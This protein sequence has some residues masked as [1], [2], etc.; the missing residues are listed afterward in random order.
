[1]GAIHRRVERLETAAGSRG[2]SHEEALREL[3]RRDEE[4]RAFCARAPE[5][6]LIAKLQA[7]DTEE[8]RSVAELADPPPPP[9]EGT[10]AR[11]F[12]YVRHSYSPEREREF[13]DQ[14]ERVA[15]VAALAGRM[16]V[17]I[18]PKPAPSYSEE[19]WPGNWAKD[20]IAEVRAQLAEGSPM[21]DGIVA[22]LQ[23][24]KC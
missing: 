4:R 12:F 10:A 5:A 22:A 8:A 2:Y 9:P 16:G 19:L 13:W 17:T 7:I 14:H 18:P 15:V 23:P 3:H 20:V 21:A 1:M 24:V 6:E 11:F